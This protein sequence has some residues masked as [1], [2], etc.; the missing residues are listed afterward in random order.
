MLT[1]FWL[2]VLTL[3][4][5]IGLAVLPLSAQDPDPVRRIGPVAQV[6]DIGTADQQLRATVGAALRAA[7][8]RV[9]VSI[10]T[11]TF[12]YGSRDDLVVANA[13]TAAAETV[14]PAALRQGVDV[15]FVYLSLPTAE[16]QRDPMQ[17]LPAGFY[18]VN[19]STVPGSSIARARL[20]NEAGRVVA[21]L[22][23]RLGGE[24][25]LP[26]ATARLK[27][28]ITIDIREDEII[29]DIHISWGSAAG[30]EAGGRLDAQVAFAL[31]E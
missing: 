2:L 7:A 24:G 5:G 25:M 19:L 14:T 8:D 17:A 21:E 29:I 26:G 20:R 3:A 28:K 23:A 22:P 9:G 4:A 27:I 30:R 13:A 15:M 6:G 12:A 18:T 16:L 31:A 11:T 1:R 10:D